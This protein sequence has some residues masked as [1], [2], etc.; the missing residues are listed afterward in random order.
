MHGSHLRP[1]RLAADSWHPQMLGFPVHST[2]RLGGSNGAQHVVS[3]VPGPVSLVHKTCT[4]LAQEEPNKPCKNKCRELA[5]LPF[6]RPA[7]EIEGGISLGSIRLT[8]PCLPAK[9]QRSTIP[10]RSMGVKVVKRAFRFH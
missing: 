5:R 2:Q 1:C 8:G 9:L 10:R 4:V 6:D 3:G 7:L